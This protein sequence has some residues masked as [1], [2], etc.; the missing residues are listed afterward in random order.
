[1]DKI[2][3]ITNIYNEEYLLPFW[4]NY[5]RKIFDHGIIIDYD[6]TD[7]SVEIVKK[8]CPTWEIRRTKNIVNGKAL[9]ETFRIEDECNEVESSVKQ[10]YKI[11]LNTTEWLVLKKP[12]REIL[13]FERKL[14]C[15]LLNVYL[16][17]YDNDNFYPTNTKDFIEK[18]DSKIVPAKEVRGFRFM[19]NRPIGCY[20]LGRHNTYIK[21]DYPPDYKTVSSL[22]RIGMCIFW[23]GYYPINNEI[24]KRKLQIKNNM[25]KEIECQPNIN[26]N[27]SFQHFYTLEEMKNEFYEYLDSKSADI[28]IKPAIKYMLSII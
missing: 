25:C 14:N 4:L 17:L 7:S 28:N 1:M 10:G 3:L 15:Y 18:F 11:Y 27:S 24:W 2:T 9:F 19:F 16:P 22:D 20:Y 21:T 6:S 13:D 26:R 5:H 8:M 12:L 23:C